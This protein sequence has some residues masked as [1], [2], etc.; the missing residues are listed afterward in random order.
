MIDFVPNPEHF[1]SIDMNF[2]LQTFDNTQVHLE[3][4]C[5]LTELGRFDGLA[6]GAFP[7]AGFDDSLFGY[8]SR[9]Q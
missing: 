9:G 2:V 5:D 6:E 7:S 1:E 3:G 8:L 4:N